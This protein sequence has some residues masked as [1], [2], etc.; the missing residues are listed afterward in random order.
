[1]ADNRWLDAIILVAMALL[2]AWISS[3]FGQLSGH[4]VEASIAKDYG[5]F[6]L[7]ALVI[8][9]AAAVNFAF[10]RFTGLGKNDNRQLVFLLIA[11]A[12]IGTLVTSAGKLFFTKILTGSIDPTLSFAFVIALAPFVEE[13]FFRGALFPSIEAFITS[14]GK[15]TYIAAGASAVIV[16]ILFSIWHIVAANGDTSA[17]TSYF[18][19]SM[20]M[21][22]LVWVTKSLAPALGAHFALNLINGG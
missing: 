14:K 1:M 8:A 7:I 21:C 12:V 15:S 11:G 22:A 9:I 4:D 6:A 20:I 17:L 5:T 18:A 3:Q 19:F 10:F 16:S 2:A 13:Y